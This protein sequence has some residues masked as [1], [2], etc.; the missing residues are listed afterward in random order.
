MREIS[1]PSGEKKETF[2][3]CTP[4]SPLNY[5]SLNAPCCV[6][7][8]E[9][10]VENAPDRLLAFQFDSPVGIGLI[11]FSCN[12]PPPVWKQHEGYFGA[13]LFILNRDQKKSSGTLL[14][15]LPHYTSGRTCGPYVR[16]SG[17][18]AYIPGRSSI[19][20]GFKRGTL[21]S[22]SLDFITM[23]PRPATFRV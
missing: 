9:S 12:D 6:S 7:A 18:Q 8:P 22:Q 1:D 11:S 15:K 4:F 3:M 5:E 19:E 23:L 13:D 17:Q 21:H 2:A 16:F 14:S 10:Q 20:S